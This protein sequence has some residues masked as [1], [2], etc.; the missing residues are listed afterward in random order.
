MQV[1]NQDHHQDQEEG[2]DTG[3]LKKDQETRLHQAKTKQ[4]TAK[5]SIMLHKAVVHQERKKRKLKD[6]KLI[7]P[8]TSNAS[9]HGKIHRMKKEQQMTATNT[10]L[11]DL[12]E[13][14]NRLLSKE[15]NQVHVVK[16]EFNKITDRFLFILSNK[17]LMQVETTNNGKWMLACDATYKLNIEAQ[18][19]SDYFFAPN[20]TTFSHQFC[21]ISHQIFFN[22]APNFQH[23]L[24]SA[25]FV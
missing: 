16:S 25:K 17:K 5:Q 13:T 21:S 3:V 11:N 1:T 19:C 2:H 12:K 24:F 9:F 8:Q 10:T 6:L 14:V 22:F 20:F 15:N 4:K 23:S 18:L 7:D